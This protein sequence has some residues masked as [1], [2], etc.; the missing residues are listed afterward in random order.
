[1]GDHR[2]E[3]EEANES[4]LQELRRNVFPQVAYKHPLTFNQYD[5]YALL[6]DWE[7]KEKV[8]NLHA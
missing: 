1:M 2:D 3:R 8:F 5:I 4:D 7:D 6:K